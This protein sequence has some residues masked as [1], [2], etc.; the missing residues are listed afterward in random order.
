MEIKSLDNVV[1][2]AFMELVFLT[3][4]F[5][6]FFIRLKLIFLFVFFAEYQY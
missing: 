6:V 4:S 1:I 5:T 2:S 3:E